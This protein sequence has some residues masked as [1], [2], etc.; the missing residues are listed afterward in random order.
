MSS[1]ICEKSDETPWFLRNLP[2]METL[3]LNE[4]MNDPTIYLGTRNLAATLISSYNQDVFYRATGAFFHGLPNY[5]LADLFDMQQNFDE[6]YLEWISNKSLEKQYKL[7]NLT[8][9][10][11]MLARAEGMTEMTTDVLREAFPQLCK[12]IRE[13]SKAR[14]EGKQVD[15]TKMSV[16]STYDK[17]KNET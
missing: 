8:C 12:L 5:M 3:N 10:A 11:F 2:K 17:P 16:L 6:E 13:N 9:L 14:K 1:L 15:Y 4:I 7:K